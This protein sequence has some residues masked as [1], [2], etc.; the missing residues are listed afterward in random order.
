M[1]KTTINHGI[2]GHPNFWHDIGDVPT[3]HVYI[4]IHTQTKLHIV[5]M[6]QHVYV[7]IMYTYVYIHLYLII[8]DVMCTH[9]FYSP[10]G[11]SIDI[12]HNKESKGKCKHHLGGVAPEKWE[13][14]RQQKSLRWSLEAHGRPNIM[15]TLP[16]CLPFCTD[17]NDCKVGLLGLGKAKPKVEIYPFQVATFH[18]DFCSACVK[19][20]YILYFIWTSILGVGGEGNI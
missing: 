7:F 19:S 15:M 3:V 11:M 10:N 6:W 18:S 13:G 8:C 14:S 17:G 9:P 5:S 20:H 1:G 2:F 4:Y 12:L 16:F